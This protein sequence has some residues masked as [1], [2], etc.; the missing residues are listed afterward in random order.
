LFLGDDTIIFCKEKPKQKPIH[1]R[2]LTKE[3]GKKMLKLEL[4]IQEMTNKHPFVY[5][6]LHKVRKTWRN[7]G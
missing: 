3:D 4:E 2:I 7:D 6:T 1:K 5:G